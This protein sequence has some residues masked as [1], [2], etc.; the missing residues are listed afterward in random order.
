MLGSKPHERA[1][2]QRRVAQGEQVHGR[3]AHERRH[4]RVHGIL[5]D[6]L[7]RSHL[8]HLA[9]FHHHDP[10]AQAH[11]LHLVVRHVNGRRLDLPLEPLQVVASGI[12]QLRV[13]VGE[14]LVE[15]KDLGIPHQRAAQRDPL[16]LP[17]R[18]LA[19]IAVEVAR[20]AEHVRRPA[21]LLL[22]PLAGRP[23]GFEREGDVLED[24]AVGVERVALEHH[25]DPPGSGRDVAVH[26]L[27]PDGNLPRRGPFEPRDHPQQGRFPRAGRAEQHEELSVADREVHTIDRVQFA[28]LFP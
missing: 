20:D 12:A 5:V 7:G 21:H 28:E 19:R 24:G 25:C 2:G 27:A 1:G 6:F 16:A 10:V 4:E 13:E 17:A 22:D 11:R 3:L 26:A 15:Q 9:V 8:P 23:T 14:G 18:E